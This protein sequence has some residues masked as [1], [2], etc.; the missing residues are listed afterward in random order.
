MSQPAWPEAAVA[1]DPAA[2]NGADSPP[3]LTPPYAQV[4]F[5]AVIITSVIALLVALGYVGPDFAKKHEDVVNAVAL[6]ASVLGPAIYALA[7]GIAQHGHQQAVAHVLV[8]KQTML[9]A[10]PLT[11]YNVS[12]GVSGFAPDVSGETSSGGSTPPVTRDAGSV[13]SASSSGSRPATPRGAR[14]RTQL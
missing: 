5:W 11:T 7:R 4:H 9:S 14:K 12:G 3:P 13:T 8:A 2:T 1:A 6:L 10:V